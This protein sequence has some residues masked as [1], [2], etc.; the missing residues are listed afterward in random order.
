M[1]NMSNE[2]PNLVTI[3]QGESEFSPLGEFQI[4]SLSPNKMTK[5]REVL[6]ALNIKVYSRRNNRFSA[7]I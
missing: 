1:T 3:S 4:K 2:A 5:V 7:S 6:S